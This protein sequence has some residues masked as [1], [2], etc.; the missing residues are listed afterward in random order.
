MPVR[1]EVNLR[2]ARPNWRRIILTLLAISIAAVILRN[3][4]GLGA[5]PR[6]EPLEVRVE[7]PTH[8]EVLGISPRATAEEIRAAYRRR[9]R[10]HHPDKVPADRAEDARRK[11]FIIQEAYTV[12]TTVMRC[13]YDFEYS[14]VIDFGENRYTRRRQCKERFRRLAKEETDRR[15]YEKQL[16]WEEKLKEQ[17]KKQKK[18]VETLLEENSRL[19]GE[20]GEEQ[21][22]SRAVYNELGSVIANKAKGIKSR[23]VEATKK[24]TKA[25][26]V[27]RPTVTSFVSRNIL[28]IGFWTSLIALVWSSDQRTMGELPRR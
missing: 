3:I 17:I 6:D 19:A 21:L 25:L 15:R 10:E 5:E 24:A 23:I 11:L 20:L 16:L 7:P 13:D 28:A 14:S 2:L 4:P 12:L 9:T 27:V 22:K 18:R 8:Y 26:S 1:L